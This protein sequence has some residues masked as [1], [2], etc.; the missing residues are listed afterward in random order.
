MDN[1]DG[2]SRTVREVFER[3]SHAIKF[4]SG[5][6]HYLFAGRGHAETYLDAEAI[7]ERSPVMANKL[8]GILFIALTRANIKPDVIVGIA[9]GGTSI[10]TDISLLY[11]KSLGK[12]IPVV[13]AGKA[14]KGFS[15]RQSA[16]ELLRDKWVLLVDDVLTAGTSS[17]MTAIAVNACG[18]RPI[19]LGVWWNR[20]LL[21]G[22]FQDMTIVAPH[23]ELLPVL[24]EEECRVKGP[25]SKG[26][27]LVS[28]GG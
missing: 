6:E 19:A 11:H 25:C 4:G 17:G 20:G 18:G 7:Q 9:S 10:A 28:G 1:G 13:V 16:Q 14:G 21:R 2:I 27:P 12:D 15:I 22:N 23:T 26:V 5:L 24:S 8:N 3:T